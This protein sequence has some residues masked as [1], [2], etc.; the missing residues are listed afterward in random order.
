[1]L[2]PEPS[3][4]LLSRLRRLRAASRW[5]REQRLEQRRSLAVQHGQGLEHRLLCKRRRCRVRGVWSD[6]VCSCPRRLSPSPA[7]SYSDM[8]YAVLLLVFN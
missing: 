2:H 6:A 7:A 4:P 3:A 8:R 1:M 5:R